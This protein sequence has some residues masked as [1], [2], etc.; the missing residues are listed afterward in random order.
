MFDIPQR[1]LLQ[2]LRTVPGEKMSA[3]LPDRFRREIIPTVLLSWRRATL[4]VFLATC[5]IALTQTSAEQVQ[6]ITSALR[7]GQFEQALQLLQPELDRAPKN[8]QLWTLRGIALSSKGDKKEALIAFRHALNVSPDYLPALEGAAQI[9][10]E[11]NGKDAAGLLEHVLRLR[12][13]DPTSHAMLAV[14]AYRRGDCTNAVSHFEQSGSLVDSQAGALKEYGDCLARLKQN[15]KAITVFTRALAQED[16]A[17]VR[18]RLALVQLMAQRPKDA[19]ATL[20]PALEQNTS[21]SELLDL[22][23]SAY[24]ADDNTPEAVRILRQAI[25]ANPHKINLYIDF[26]VLCL[27]HRSFQVGVDMI[28]AGLKF[29]P[30]SAALYATRGVLYVQVSEFEKAEAD[31]EKADNLDPHQ[32]AASAALGLAAEQKNDPDRALAI[33]QAKLAK[34]PNNAFLLYL[35]ADILQQRGLQLDSPEF[36]LALQSAKRAV[37]L[38]PSLTQAHDVLAKLYLRAGQKQAAIQQCHEALNTDPKDQTAIYRLVMALRDNDPTHDVPKLLKRL[39]DLRAEDTKEE[40]ERNRY[41]L[42]ENTGPEEKGQPAKGHPEKDHPEK[43]Q[44]ET[45]EP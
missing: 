30:N 34:H 7:A 25:V 3:G 35:Q 41:K 44:S 24:E 8:P 39:A 1:I 9:E 16:D 10:Y 43:D 19:I 5:S 15:E 42:V 13:D 29:E 4:L 23:S 21:D 31:F 28:N 40:S 14:L 32:S 6:S 11:N 22:A 17:G 26:A 37:A 18:Y 12:P 2:L 27:D 36:R 33:V 20:Q 45:N 38:R